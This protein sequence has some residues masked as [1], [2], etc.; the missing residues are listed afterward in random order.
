MYGILAILVA[1]IIYH[2][3]DAIPETIQ[4]WWK[5]TSLRK[6]AYPLFVIA[7]TVGVAV[8]LKYDVLHPCAVGFPLLFGFPY[9]AGMI[10]GIWHSMKA[11]GRRLTDKN[12]MNASEIAAH[13]LREIGCQPEIKNDGTIFVSYQGEKFVM[14][15]GERSARVWDP[16]WAAIAFD[17]PDLPEI[18]EAVNA[19]NFSFGP[20]VVVTPPDEEGIVLLHSYRDIM[21]HPSCPE[22][23]QYIRA[24]LDSF[25]DTV[26]HVRRNFK[27]IS[28]QQQQIRTR[29][30]VG[31]APPQ[32]PDIQ[33][34]NG[35][36]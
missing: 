3:V 8:G 27:Q 23:D 31:F 33:Q 22:N 34:Q 7:L 26:E 21:L 24:V 35:S 16:G 36:Y 15:F 28:A 19:N 11:S 20:T 13:C 12:V 29:R 30:P 4:E 17:D 1:V 14:V 2:C 32:T 10:M 18:R 25:F 9:L 5:N 6:W